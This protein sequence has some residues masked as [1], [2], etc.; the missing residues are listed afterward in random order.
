MFVFNFDNYVHKP[1]IDVKHVT[2]D[3]NKDLANSYYLARM[4][5]AS[6]YGFG[7]NLEGTYFGG[8]LN[9]HSMF[10]VLPTASY[11]NDHPDW[12]YVNAAG[13]PR[14]L[15]LTNEDMRKAFVE[16]LIKIVE[17]SPKSNYYNLGN[18]DSSEICNCAKCQEYYTKYG[19]AQGAGYIYVNFLNEVSEKVDEWLAANQPERLGK[20][21]V[22]G[23]AYFGYSTS[24]TKYDEKTGEFSP[25]DENC[26]L[27]DNVFMQFVTHDSCM[28][29]ALN[30]ENCSYNKP[31]YQKY[32]GWTAITKHIKFYTYSALNDDYFMYYNDF[33]AIQ[34]NV[35]LLRE[36]GVDLLAVE[37]GRNGE[38]PFD[39]LRFYLYAKLSDNPDQDFDTLV[40][41]FM[42]HYYKDAGELIYQFYRNLRDNFIVTA[43]KLGEPICM[44]VYS[45][46]PS[47]T[48]KKNDKQYWPYNFLDSSEKIFAEA[49]EVIAASSLSET[50]KT[51]MN[52][53]IDY[54]EIP[55]RYTL[56]KHYSAYYPEDRIEDIKA[57]FLKEAKAIGWWHN[58]IFTQ[59]IK[60]D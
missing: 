49:K 25:I 39:S 4:G 15:C 48:I 59:E 10:S 50:D 34:Q 51:R 32:K 20:V 23:L 12:Y 19:V 11:Y 45:Y 1:A 17:V 56:L 2:S 24:P 29:H 47:M 57:Q 27:R 33:G 26:V 43:N 60:F 38:G 3:Y 16:S 53:H 5:L 18:E 30:D 41:K 6:S 13:K 8:G 35:K 22:G 46:N 9:V 31:F 55:I 54:L 58:S 52:L 36:T 40:G 21:M 44:G 37:G 7:S 42:A 14:Q 28:A